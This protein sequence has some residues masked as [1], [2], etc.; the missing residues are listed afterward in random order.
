MRKLI[1][2]LSFLFLASQVS[3]FNV[4][5]EPG[6][7]LA[8][9]IYNNV[10][11][12]FDPFDFNYTSG[13]TVIL[14]HATDLTCFEMTL[15]GIYGQAYGVLPLSP[16]STPSIRLD[17]TAYNVAL[18]CTGLWNYGSGFTA[19]SGTMELTIGNGTVLSLT[20]AVSQVVPS[21]TPSSSVTPS[22]SPSSSASSSAS[23]TISTTSSI[24]PSITP[25][26]SPSVSESSSTSV[27]SQI[28]VSSSSGV[29]PQGFEDELQKQ[30]VNRL[31]KK[32]EEHLNEDLIT[33]TLL[34]LDETTTNT[35]NS[36][37]TGAPQFIVTIENC[38]MTPYIT[39]LRTNSPIMNTQIDSLIDSILPVIPSVVCNKMDQIAQNNLTV[40]INAA[41]DAL[42]TGY[43]NLASGESPFI[44]NE[45]SFFW[46]FL[47]CT[48]FFLALFLT[49]CF[50]PGLYRQYA[51]HKRVK[52]TLNGNGEKSPLMG[53]D[54][55]GDDNIVGRKSSNLAMIVDPRISWY[56]R[57][58]ILLTMCWNVAL[59]ATS[60][61]SVASSVYLYLTIGPSVIQLPAI[62]QFKI[63]ESV[64]EMW[65]AGVWELSLLIG[66]ASGIWP[67]VKLVLMFFCF[68]TPPKLF[69]PKWRKRVLRLLDILGKWSLID[70]F[71]LVF[72]IEAFRVHVPFN[73]F[74]IFDMAVEPQYAFF[75]YLTATVISLCMSHILLYVHDILEEPKIPQNGL[76]D[77]LCR[78]RF[79]FGGL[80]CTTTYL[81][82]STIVFCIA[83]AALALIWGVM[84]TAFE[85]NW[86]GSLVGNLLEVVDG[87]NVKEYSITSLL[88]SIP[89]TSFDSPDSFGIRTIQVAFCLF[90]IVLPL[91]HLISLLFIWLVPLTLEMQK[92]TYIIVEIL[93]AWSAIDVFI[94][95]LIVALL[96]LE[97]FA[98]YIVEG[99][100]LG[101]DAFLQSISGNP[102][103]TCFTVKASLESGSWVLVIA[104]LFLV[105]VGY[106]V[107]IICNISVHDRLKR[108]RLNIVIESGSD[109]LYDDPSVQVVG[110]PGK[111]SSQIAKGLKTLW[112]LKQL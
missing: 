60:T 16:G 52:G 8:A 53:L 111:I 28:S 58:L 63:V 103:A 90:V 7:T 27:V 98:S 72:F 93:S 55:D 39:Y 92:A 42:Y 97:Q 89:D 94:V 31:M 2:V 50:L 64:I 109:D 86:E 57:F 67:Y 105:F 32:I 33:K 46:A 83:V 75:S 49:L 79:T 71:V 88:T 11:L 21:P 29:V 34:V 66:V 91:L 24:T 25:S 15:D 100:C 20:V 95:A 107:L 19:Q 18:N 84:V 44:F 22:V 81:A 40:V 106:S 10:T 5:V 108:D 56:W 48:V 78:H 37:T 35:G 38:A 14:V 68:V 43:Q 87:Y 6:S 77:T 3:A 26:N 70:V 80:K 54:I 104:T 110:T 17:A 51:D 12:K 61:S 62:Y 74:I 73:E 99:I 65:E 59:F 30:A 9:F 13:D 82:R 85:L 102:D 112:C 47:T 4:T 41:S 69:A 76:M 45:L 36:S 96:Q 101:I 1:V 23:S